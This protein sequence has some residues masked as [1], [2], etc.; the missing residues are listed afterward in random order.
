M[1]L[2]G[3]LSAT[4]DRAVGATKNTIG[5]VTGNTQL[6]AEGLAQNAVGRA[7]G[8]DEDV[9]DTARDILEDQE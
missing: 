4:T 5:A 6:Q 1:G 3:R 9:E 8:H 7:E 2:V